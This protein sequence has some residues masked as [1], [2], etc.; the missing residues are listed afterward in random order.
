M[1]LTGPVFLPAAIRTEPP[2]SHFHHPENHLFFC[3]AAPFA[4]HFPLLPATVFDPPP[5]A[6]PGCH[7][8]LQDPAPACPHC[9]YNGWTCVEK[10]PWIPPPLERVMDVDDRLSPADR[11]LLDK[12]IEP[13]EQSLP[14]IRVHVCLGRLHPDTDPRE[15]GFWLFNASVPPDAEAASHRPWSVLL[16]IDRAS[17]RASLTIG[18]GL[19]PFVSDRHLTTCL[20]AA[21]PE[22]QRSRYGPGA[23]TCLKK[24]H[25]LLSTTQRDSTGTATRFRQSIK[26]GTVPP[27]MLR[28]CTSLARRNAY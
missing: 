20:E 10:F 21:Q 3:L 16:V 26:D 8:T 28:D 13:L 27:A 1:G 4:M 24:L 12:V 18:Y 9:G 23:A 15:F 5:V 22:F 17:R 11:L 19:D 7:A 25:T 14:Q 6:C 2:F